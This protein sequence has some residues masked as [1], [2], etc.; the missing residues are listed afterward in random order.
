[1]NE[2]IVR[3]NR[4][5]ENKNEKAFGVRAINQLINGSILLHFVSNHKNATQLFNYIDKNCCYAFGIG[6]KM[7]FSKMDYNMTIGSNIIL[8]V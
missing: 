6:L 4:F 8:C 1:M 5:A 7:L 2:S 3:I